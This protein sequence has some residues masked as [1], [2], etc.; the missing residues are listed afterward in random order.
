MKTI[1]RTAQ[2]LFRSQDEYDPSLL[3]EA[4]EKGYTQL[5]LSVGDW[6]S[7]DEPINLLRRVGEDAAQLGMQ[8]S[9]LTGYQ[10]YAA[11]ALAEHP[12]WRMVFE[13]GS[14]GW[15]AC[16][17]HEDYQAL[18]V[19]AMRKVAQIPSVQEIQLNDEAHLTDWGQHWGCYC[20]RCIAQFRSEA[21]HEPP[22]VL[23]WESDLWRRWIQWRFDNWVRVHREIYDAVKQV[24]PSVLL[25]TQFDPAVCLRGWN[26]WFSGVDIAAM[27][28]VMDL[29]RVDPYHTYHRHDYRPD[30][31]FL[32]EN[33]RYLKGAMAGKPVRI[34]TQGMT[35]PE[36]SRPLTAADGHWT[37]ALPLA[38]GAESTTYW[39]YPLM[40]E[41]PE[42]A[43]AYE[44]SFR[45]DRYYGE[46]E[47]VR[48]AA[49][50]Q[51]WQTKVW[52]LNQVREGRAAYDVDYFRP[53]CYTLRRAH[54]PYE[55]L[56]D[57]RLASD[58]LS[59]LRVLL[60]PRVSCMSQEQ[61]AAVRGF[62]GGVVAT[63]DTGCY[64]QVGKRVD[65]QALAPRVRIGEWGTFGGIA[66][67]FPA[68]PLFEG[69]EHERLAF[70]AYAPHVRAD[71]TLEVLATFLDPSGKDT[72]V[73]A[74]AASVSEPRFLYFAFE[75]WGVR[76]TGELRRAL[77]EI[78]A[79][80]LAN[81][82]RW[83]AGSAPPVSLEEPAPKGVELFAGE[84]QD[85]YVVTLGNY[86]LEHD[87]V[88]LRLALPE[89]KGLALAYDAEARRKCPVTKT[90][91]RSVQIPVPLEG[92]AVKVIVL[93]VS[94]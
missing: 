62:A 35:W 78:C 45:W 44:G 12:E 15:E 55:H 85:R 25:S 64:D 3:L 76:S 43:S 14:V 34:W 61:A 90:G 38:L 41:Q 40:Q 22:R 73:P 48:Y 27:A 9:I 56:W 28:G 8:L 57:R 1:Y 74:I 89:G 46:T 51:G 81:A 7:S 67:R 83:A 39:A 31:T 70:T 94:D 75:P 52:L 72:D 91:D 5:G 33:I 84:G 54:V 71:S 77:S 6:Y 29:L 68:H 65:R 24:R 63:S 18:Y 13:D 87:V 93:H 36:F 49:V 17:F 23:D 82:V 2:M 32:P 80:M 42:V 37:A 19:E 88:T 59:G 20:E 92:K 53:P 11:T 4:K 30:I 60:L 47:P 16:P 50:V 58:R 86:Y 10:R 21:G 66:V 69:V 26:P 79:G